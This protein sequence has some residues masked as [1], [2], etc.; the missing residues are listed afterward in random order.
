MKTLGDRAHEGFTARRFL[1]VMFAAVL[2]ADLFCLWA[3]HNSQYQE[4]WKLFTGGFGPAVALLSG[5]LAGPCVAAA[6]LIWASLEWV[7]LRLTSR[8]LW[9]RA[10]A[11]VL[12]CF[13]GPG[14]VLLCSFALSLEGTLVRGTHARIRSEFDVP[15]LQ[16]WA[17]DVQSKAR[18]ATEAEEKAL[19]DRL[20]WSMT[21]RDRLVFD[22][23]EIRPAIQSVFGTNVVVTVASNSPTEIYTEIN[24]DA[25]ALFIGDTGNLME[26]DPLRMSQLAP[27]VYLCRY[28][29]P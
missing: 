15:E 2:M 7:I 25:V 3:A 29:R 8:Q 19:W 14:L 22:H 5:F 6:G 26:R 10:I 1:L 27:G 17:K 21:P 4:G 13:G 18:I 11:C 9:D 12:V 24:G 23:L 16:R 28:V 20:Y